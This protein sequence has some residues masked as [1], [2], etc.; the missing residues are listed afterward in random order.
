MKKEWIYAYLI[1][2][3]VRKKKQIRKK[4]WSK[5]FARENSIWYYWTT[6]VCLE[7]RFSFSSS[8]SMKFFL[9]FHPQCW[10]LSLQLRCFRA[11]RERKG[12]KNRAEHFEFDVRPFLLF[13]LFLSF[14]RLS[15][16]LYPNLLAS[17]NSQKG[18]PICLQYVVY[19][20]LVFAVVFSFFLSFA[21]ICFCTSFVH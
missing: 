6:V 4:N 1:T 19:L 7:C 5:N 20:L 10:F 8:L 18:N 9:S 2:L 14:D 12:G 11:E 17:F 13:I 3:F 21:S 16:H 15:T